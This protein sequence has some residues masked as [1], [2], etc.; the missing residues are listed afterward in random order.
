MRVGAPNG[1]DAVRAYQAQQ[2]KEKAGSKNRTNGCDQTDRL[3]ISAGARN[4]QQYRD[5][6]AAMPAVRE[7]LVTALQQSIQAGTYRPEPEKIAAG[8]IAERH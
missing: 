1:Y 3:E 6:L 5:V 7:E 8:I 2:T 4:M